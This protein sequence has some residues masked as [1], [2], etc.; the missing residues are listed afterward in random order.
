VGHGELVQLGIQRYAQLI[1]QF[2]GAAARRVL[3]D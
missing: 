2:K 3:A 1:E